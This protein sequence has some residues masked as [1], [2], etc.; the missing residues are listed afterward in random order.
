MP[1]R[2]L[3]NVTE[4][5]D[6][7][8]MA[9][10][11]FGYKDDGT[12]NRK[13]FY[14][15]SAAE[16]AKKLSD[17]EKQVENGLNVDATSLTFEQ[18]LKLWL[19][20]Y[21]A[22][23]VAPRTYDTYETYIN[24]R[25]IP[26]LGKHK[27]LKLRVDHLQ[28]FI[29]GLKKDNGEPLAV[30]TIVKIKNILNG[31]LEQAVKN[32]LITR[33]PVTAL[34]L[35]KDRDKKKVGAFTPKEQTALLKQLQGDRLYALFVVALGTGMRIGEILALKWSAIDFIQNEI[36]VVASVLRTKDRDAKGDIEGSSIK[37][38]ATKT[39]AG[40]RAIPLTRQVWQ[41]LNEHKKQQALERFKAGGAWNDN[42]L[43]FCNTLGGF[44]E[45]R[46]VT[47]FYEK[48]REQAGIS[49]HSFHSL[50]HSFAT[51]AITAGMDYYYLSRLMGHASISIT[52]DTYAD[53][54]PDKS[55]SEMNKMEDVLYLKI[56]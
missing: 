18:W 39:K 47:R 4:R 56:A 3:N 41:A 14:G 40:F 8:F 30:Q 55:R 35:P 7:R 34:T 5:K 23:S 19:T 44:L 32:G 31:A 45:Y 1:K 24:S 53:Y 13:T 9:R 50:R 2:K 46:N 15:D 16:V 43:V 54:M 12:P 51:N 33:N 26:A 27:M 10:K 36:K 28:A 37:I 22:K 25:I 29:N 20:E 38:N 11:T 49:K 42:N 17:Y 6:G 48:M 21:K 52:L